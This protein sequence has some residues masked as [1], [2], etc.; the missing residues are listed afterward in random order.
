MMNNI[1]RYII[2]AE[3]CI[4][5]FI[6]TS[7]RADAQTL[8][9][10]QDESKINS[11]KALQD[12]FPKADLM[13]I[14]VF[15]YPEQ[16]PHNE[17]ERDF[18]NIASFGFDFTHL[19]EFSWALLEPVEGKYDF[20]WLDEAIDMADKAGLK[21]ILCTP[22]LC[23]PA[24]MGEKY[25]EVY[26]VG[27]E[28]R[29]REHG[30]RAN[31]SLANPVYRNF[32]DEIVTAMAIHYS[33]D[34]RIWGWQVDNEPLAVPDYS[35]SAHESFIIWLKN[36]YGTIEKLNDAWVGS[37]W[38]TKYFSFDQVLIPNETLAIE[39][40]LSPHALLDFKR[41]TADVTADFLNRQADILRAYILPEQWITTNYINVSMDADPR[42]SDHL[43]FPT[44]TMYPVSGKNELGGNN[45]RTGIPYRIYEACDYYRPIKGKTGLME[46]QPGQVN[47]GSINPQLLPGTVHMWIMQA[48][49]GGCS[50]LCTYRYRHPLRGSEMYHEGIVG[51]DG[52]TLSQGG[53]EFVQAIGE[54]KKFRQLYDA[55]AKMPPEFSKRKTA[56]LWNHE[57]MWD[58]D[59]QKQ[60]TLWNSWR[61]R[62]NFTSAVK[63]TGAPMDFISEDDNFSAYPFII[64][65]SYQ[66]IDNNLV[67]KW[68]GYVKNGGNLILSSRTG[69]KDRNSHFFEAAW[70][71]LLKPLIGADLDFFD[72]LVA[73][74]TGT[75]NTGKMSFK[76]N[77]WADILS[78][79]KGTEI[80]ASFADQYY[81]GK[82]AAVTRKIGKGTVTYIGVTTHDGQLE[83]YLVRE[84]YKRANVAIEDLPRGVYHEWRDGFNIAVNYTDRPF[85]VSIKD[86]GTILIG[87]NPLKTAGAIVWKTK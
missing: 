34:K 9:L 64:A 55:N 36:K 54:M 79:E 22:S 32:T 17:W 50:F 29:R 62:N 44:F 45:F 53:K 78:P 71:A 37:F 43:D 87:N 77:V 63:S 10:T 41:Y 70:A 18:K 58:L 47:W 60:T 49:G 30:N 69:M 14:G 59:I 65:P 68:I 66:L 81:A 67:N 13:K 52:V 57:N 80:L 74:T 39:D 72:M 2:I 1:L 3:Y 11:D 8:P 38:S 31:A 5:F 56:I 6:F 20:S 28:G 51:T 15:Y 46:L 27:P 61:N 86:E 85:R 25:P 82:A 40:K 73:D 48:F 7:G 16:W 35:P 84:I 24:W 83:R 75:V 19:A 21:V 12:F 23:P 4:L 76:W 26:L 33:K 42:R